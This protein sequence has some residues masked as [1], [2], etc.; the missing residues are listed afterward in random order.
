[1]YKKTAIAGALFTALYGA[2]LVFSGLMLWTGVAILRSVGE[3]HPLVAILYGLFGDLRSWEVVFG[4]LFGGLIGVITIVLAIVIGIISLI[5]F[6][7]SIGLIGKALLKKD[8]RRKLPGT[9]F[10]LVVQGFIVV[11]LSIFNVAAI[12]SVAV[13]IAGMVLIILDVVKSG[14]TA[15]QAALT[16]TIK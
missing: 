12:G 2:V 7:C 10:F 13:I 16:D 1:M 15:A 6:L 8:Y 3:S 5:L 9:I 14:K 4:G 11:A